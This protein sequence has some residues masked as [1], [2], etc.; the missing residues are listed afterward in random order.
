M[1]AGDGSPVA[2]AAPADSRTRLLVFGVFVPIAVVA[3]GL[4]SFSLGANLLVLVVGGALFWAGLAYR[5]DGAPPPARRWPRGAR[6]WLLPV[7]VLTGVEAVSYLLGS[8]PEH[9]TFSLL[10]DPWLERS[11]VRAAAFLGWMA[12]FWGMV[13]R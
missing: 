7:G 1:E 9:P 3:G 4:P 11:P 12:A 10:A 6:R 8:T 13:R 5:S 2:E